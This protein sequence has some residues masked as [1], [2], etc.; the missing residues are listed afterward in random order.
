MSNKMSS[1]INSLK[2]SEDSK[3]GYEHL[4]DAVVLNTV[5]AATSI[6]LDAPNIIEEAWKRGFIQDEV[7]VWHSPLEEKNN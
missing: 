7:G 6:S 4:P 1:D 3:T 2:S 5:I